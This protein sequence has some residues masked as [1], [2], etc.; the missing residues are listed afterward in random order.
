M[1]AGNPSAGEQTSEALLCR[2]GFQRNTVEKQL[3]ARGG[4]QKPRFVIAESG[5]QLLPG[6]FVL[7][8]GARMPEVIHSGKFKQNIEAANESP[9]SCGLDAYIHC[10]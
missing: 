1:D 3:F 8:S 4:E 6:G 10:E 7:C 9:C 2:R 5:S